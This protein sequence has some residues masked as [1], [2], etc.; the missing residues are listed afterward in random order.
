MD[1]APPDFD[2]IATVKHL[3]AGEREIANARVE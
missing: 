2:W 1:D 3:S